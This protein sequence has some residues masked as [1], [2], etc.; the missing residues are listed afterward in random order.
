MRFA[1]HPPCIIVDIES[2]SEC[3]LIASGA[4]AY[5]RHPTTRILVLAFLVPEPYRK[6]WGIPTT[7][8]AII[9]RDGKMVEQAEFLP[10]FDRLRLALQSGWYLTAHNAYF[11]RCLWHLTGILSKMFIR[12]DCTMSR[13]KMLG[14]PGSL[15]KQGEILGL[16]TRKDVSDTGKKK[17]LFLCAPRP[18]NGAQNLFGIDPKW[19]HHTEDNLRLLA[20]YCLRDCETTAELAL[21]VPWWP[22]CDEYNTWHMLMAANEHGVFL[23]LPLCKWVQE[24]SEVSREDWGRQVEAATGG[25]VTRDDLN[26]VGYL[27]Q[28]CGMEGDALDKQSVQAALERADLPPA[29]RTVLLAR[30]TTAKTSAAKLDVM[31]NMAQGDGRIHDGLDYYGTGNG[32]FSGKAW[33]PQNLPRESMLEDEIDQMLAQIPLP[34]GMHPDDRPGWLELI[35]ALW[36]DPVLIASRCIRGVLTAAP[37]YQQIGADYGQIEARG[38]MWLSQ[39]PGI[40]IFSQ[41]DPYK[42]VAGLI[43]DIDPSQVTKKQRDEDGKPGVLGPGYGLGVQ[44]AQN[45]YGFDLAKAEKVIY[46]YRNNFPRVPAL[47]R[48][49]EAAAI[50]ACAAPGHDIQVVGAKSGTSFF[51]DGRDLWMELPSGSRI[52]Y[53]KAHIDYFIYKGKK[54]EQIVY[55]GLNMGEEGTSKQWGPETTYGG[56][57]T[58]NAV[59]RLSRDIMVVGWRNVLQKWPGKLNVSLT[60]HDELLGDFP[61]IY[62]G[63]ITV[64]KFCAA[65]VAPMPVWADGWPLKA[66]GWTGRRFRK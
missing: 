26:R 62:A 15:E 23:D 65:M 54:R 21:K 53:F 37:T 3:D 13:G 10:F 35:R 66:S 20:Q 39:D 32:R 24:W 45:K 44:G 46:T 14:L 25:Q 28:F 43:H 8:I 61:E 33:Q 50:K 27:A 19:E 41:G 18:A 16:A 17:M 58:Q 4:Y 51:H 30:R 36:D 57:L 7:G 40:K 64:E 55:L 2:A 49:M 48:E 22:S 63:D 31:V 59:S 6:L 34:S 47:W 12:W 1:P 52:C 11:E 29:A 5:S 38:V 9:Y 42:I 56:K 60:I